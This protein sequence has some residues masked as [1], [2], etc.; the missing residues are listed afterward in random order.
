MG[1]LFGALN[2]T[3]GDPE[4]RSVIIKAKDCLRQ[5]AGYTGEGE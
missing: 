5:A 4:S 1:D 3:E 2:L